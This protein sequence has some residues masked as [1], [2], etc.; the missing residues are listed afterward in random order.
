M[1]TRRIED[2]GAVAI[3]YRPG[4]GREQAFDLVRR[5][6]R[7]WGFD[8]FVAD[9]NPDLPF[10]L[11]E[12]RNNAVRLVE[13]SEL[14]PGVVV[15]CDADTIPQCDVIR[16]AIKIASEPGHVIYPFTDYRY[17]SSQ[18]AGRAEDV[19][20]DTLIETDFGA[21][22]TPIWNKENSVGGVIVTHSQTYWDLG[23]MDEKFERC[24]GFED[25]AFVAVADTLAKVI[26]LPGQV[27]SFSHE[28]EG[29]GR[30]WSKLN[31]NYWRNELYQMC[32]GNP[33]LMREL[34]KK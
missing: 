22:A 9:S 33:K 15:V 6:W 31:P 23:G 14:G 13:Q 16:K 21:V 10:S 12:A 30:D 7:A 27:Y 26:R 19:S 25:N 8:V 3:P 1:G 34:V 32:W 17:I 29:V 20:D 18:W 24:W 5:W 2:F 28:V 11:S 4:P